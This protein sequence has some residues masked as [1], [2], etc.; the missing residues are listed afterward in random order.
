MSFLS[1]P[2]TLHNR[3][4]GHFLLTSPV[5][6]CI[7]RGPNNHFVINNV[8]E[9]RRQPDGPLPRGLS[10]SGPVTLSPQQSSSLSLVNV[11]MDPSLT[12]WS[13]GVV[14]TTLQRV[15]SSVV[16]SA[17][18]TSYIL[19]PAK[20][21]EKVSK[22]VVIWNSAIING[23]PIEQDAKIVCLISDHNSKVNFH[24]NTIFNKSA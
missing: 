2:S 16:L 7:S 5:L 21:E 11:W 9:T 8:K 15:H 13:A 4:T 24:K 23:N 22:N 10:V 19:H 1:G 6:W 17:K 14:V 18:Y 12:S 20:R 3:K